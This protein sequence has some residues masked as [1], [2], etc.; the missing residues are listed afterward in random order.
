VFSIDQIAKRVRL[1]E[2]RTN[3][4]I[5]YTLAVD[6]G[7]ELIAENL[8]S[9]CT[10]RIRAILTWWTGASRESRGHLREMARALYTVPPRRL[11]L[12]EFT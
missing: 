5:Q 1:R 11:G 12:E 7:N 10:R 9:R 4:L 8:T 3:D 6:R 2:H